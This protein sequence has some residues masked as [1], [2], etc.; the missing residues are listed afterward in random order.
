MKK[1]VL[2]AEILF[3]GA[4]FSS[5]TA[6]WKLKNAK[7]KNDYGD[8]YIMHDESWNHFGDKYKH[9]TKRGVICSIDVTAWK[10]SD[11]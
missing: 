4:F 1:A 11:V 9:I 5:L 10:H 2:P 3:F 6:G 8:V 7:Q